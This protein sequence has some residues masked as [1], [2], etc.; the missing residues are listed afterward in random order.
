MAGTKVKV[1]GGKEVQ[2][3]NVAAVA[4]LKELFGSYKDL[5]FADYRG[6]TFEQISLLRAQLR[7]KNAMF[8]VVKN[9]AAKIALQQL[10]QPDVSAHL[11]GPTA[12][13]LTH[14]DSAAIAK[15]LFDYSRET[16][17][18]IKGGIIEGGVFDSRQVEDFSKLPGRRELLAMLMGT[19]NAPIQNFVYAVSGVT[20]KLVRTLAAVAESKTAGQGA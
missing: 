1:E 13:A 15:M 10:H 17:L 3:K 6:L 19:M 8:K 18:A 16:P 2:Q 4:S 5:I 11:T 14:E 7:E 20:Q 9:R 12:V